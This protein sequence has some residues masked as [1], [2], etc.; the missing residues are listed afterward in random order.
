M[1][2]IATV[3]LAL[4]LLA[5]CASAADTKTTLKNDK[6]K[7]SYSI[8]Y[9]IAR[10]MKLAGQDINTD[11]FAAAMKDVYAGSKLQLTDEQVQKFLAD[12]KK[13]GVQTT[14]SGQQY[15][16]SYTINIQV[17]FNSTITQGTNLVR[18]ELR[19]GV[20]GT[21]TVF[22]TKFF[23]GRTATVSFAAMPAGTYFIAIGNG[24]SVAVGPVRQ[25]KNGQTVNTNVRVTS[26][27][28]NI[29]TRSRRGL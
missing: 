8:G 7:V 3:A 16:A 6:D 22:D 5:S 26:S 25:F 12:F 19:Q 2:A 18:V 15:T 17:E 21:S 27:S 14:W 20:P 10:R 13:E 1:K 29:G 4:G 11:A 28:G 23:E 9:N 24:D